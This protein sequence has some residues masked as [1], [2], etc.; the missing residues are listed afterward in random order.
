MSVSKLLEKNLRVSN[1]KPAQEKDDT[2]ET[3]KI[4]N[5]N[6]QARQM[7]GSRTEKDLQLLDVK[8]KTAELQYSM[9]SGRSVLREEI[10]P[11]WNKIYKSASYFGDFGQRYAADWAA[12]LGVSDTER[13]DKLQKII[14]EATELFIRDFAENVLGEM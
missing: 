14:D 9:L 12:A 7:A 5:V 3:V 8:V 11:V 6:E 2:Q 4:H 13:I 1:K 10:Q